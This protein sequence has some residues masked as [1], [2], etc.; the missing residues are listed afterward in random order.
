MSTKL[1]SCMASAGLGAAV[2]Y[3]CDP[4]RGRRRRALIQDQLNHFCSQAAKATDVVR[5]DATNRLAGTIAELRGATRSDMVS[6]EVLADRVR[7][8]LGRFV[9]HAAAIDVKTQGGCV[10]LEGPILAA[11]VG[12]LVAAVRRVRG[13]QRVVNRLKVYR[14]PGNV[15]ALQGGAPAR[16]AAAE[17]MQDSWSPSARGALGLTGLGL[18]TA[19]VAQRSP[20]ALLLGAIGFG[21][22]MRAITNAPM[23]QW[24][25]AGPP[26]G[27][28]TMRT[29]AQRDAR[30]LAGNGRRT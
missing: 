17:I 18:M 5:R 1:S 22:A 19:C 11:E 15:S 2:M 28:G 8:R 21:L 24:C 14:E 16:G 6:D 25:D 30:T 23:T 20:G 9:S 4:D 26:A 29:A 3:L 13:V 27:R 10:L 7:A 12:P